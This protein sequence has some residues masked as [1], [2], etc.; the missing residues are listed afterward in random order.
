[1]CAP[2]ALDAMCADITTRVTKPVEAALTDAGLTLDD[3]H[4]VELVGA[5]ICFIRWRPVSQWF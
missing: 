2:Q 5:F 1:M 4:A 3:I